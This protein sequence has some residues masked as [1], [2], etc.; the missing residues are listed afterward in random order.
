MYHVS[1]SATLSSRQNS[2]SR[3][4]SGRIAQTPA[5]R[6]VLVPD[7]ADG[8]QRRWQFSLHILG[9]SGISRR[10]RR[11]CQSC[12]KPGL[13]FPV[14]CGPGPGYQGR[15]NVSVR[16]I[17]YP[18]QCGSLQNLSTTFYPGWLQLRNTRW[19]LQVIFLDSRNIGNDNDRY[20]NS[21]SP[22]S[23]PWPNAF[24]AVSRS[25]PSM[26]LQSAM[27]STCSPPLADRYCRERVAMVSSQRL[28]DLAGAASGSL[29]KVA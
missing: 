12:L 29:R 25:L 22:S 4:S 6:P 9:H 10:S 17:N 11:L 7:P 16:R 27:L 26:A 15:S 3:V 14:T 8:Y 2:P 5:R 21:T 19:V 24:A 23:Q 1:P 18:P 13:R 20:E 28:A